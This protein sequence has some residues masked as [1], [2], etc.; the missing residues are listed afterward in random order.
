VIVGQNVI[1]VTVGDSRNVENNGSLYKGGT[2]EE[3]VFCGPSCVFTNV[4]NPRS[5][6]ERKHEFRPHP[7]PARRHN[8]RQ[9]HHCLRSRHRSIR[10]PRRG[11]GGDRR[12]PAFALMAGVPASRIGWVAERAGVKLGPD[13][14]CPRP[15]RRYNAIAPDVLEECV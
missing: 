9:R 8:R 15:E 10:V 12:G 11:R 3:D 13:L 1:N 4:A 5:E 14:V 7:R 6:I 2:L